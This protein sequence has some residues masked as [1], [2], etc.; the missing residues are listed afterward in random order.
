[1]TKYGRP[2][3]TRTGTPWR[4]SRCFPARKHT[5]LL[6]AFGSWRRSG[7]KRR[8]GCDSSN[9]LAMRKRASFG[10]RIGM[11]VPPEFLSASLRE[12]GVDLAE[13]GRVGE[14]VEGSSCLNALGGANESAPGDLRQG[15]FY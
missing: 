14:G 8:R 12:D 7:T 1:P 4:I 5:S 2:F 15:R 3:S 11:P 9:P 13:R 6:S 10:W